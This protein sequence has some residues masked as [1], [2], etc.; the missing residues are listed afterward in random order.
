[1]AGVLAYAA[2]LGAWQNFPVK[3]INLN[4]APTVKFYEG[5]S[6]ASHGLYDVHPV[7]GAV[8]ADGSYVMAGKAIEGESSPASTYKRMFCIKVSSTGTVDWVWGHNPDEKQ[9]AGNAVMQL[10]TVGG[11]HGDIIVVGYQTKDSKFQRSITKLA[12]SNGNH[13]WSATWASTDTSMNGAWEMI[14]MTS[15]GQHVLLAGNSE[16]SDQSEFN[17]KS[18]GTSPGLNAP[19]LVIAV[20]LA[21]PPVHPTSVVS[22]SATEF[23][24]DLSRVIMVS[25]GNVISGT[26]LVQKLPVSKLTASSA[27][28]ASD[29]TWTYTG[30]GYLTSKAARGLSDGSVVA[31][32][33]AA[34]VEK[35]AALVKLSSAGAVTW[36]PTDFA[37]YHG[38]GTDVVV[39]HDQKS[40]VICGQGPGHSSEPAG[41]SYVAGSYFGRLT[42]VSLTGT[43]EWSKSYTSTPYD[44]SAGTYATLIKNECW[45]I[46]PA[47]DGYVVGCGTGI[48]DC[49]YDAGAKKD[50]CDA[51]TPDTRTGAIKRAAS[52]WQ[53]MVF[54]VN[55]AGE[56]QWLRTDQYRNTEDQPNDCAA[57]NQGACKSSA[58]EYPII[59]SD[60]GITS[61]QDEGSGIG[62]LRLNPSHV[63]PPPPPPPPK[64]PPAAAAVASSP[65]PTP[66]PPPP[67]PGAPGAEPIEVITFSLVVAGDL[68]TFDEAAFKINL[69]ASLEGAVTVEDIL[70]ILT[71]ASVNVE[72]KIKAPADPTLKAKTLS[73]LQSVANDPAAASAALGVKVEAIATA[74]VV[75]TVV[76]SE[77]EM[78]KLAAGRSSNIGAIVGGAV[79]GT[80]GVLLLIAFLWFF[81]KRGGAARVVDVAPSRSAQ[82]RKT[83]L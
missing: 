29:V 54:R 36:G 81:K 59:T 71:A 38:E 6:V 12:L 10:P 31:L 22:L 55:L 32:L 52:I 24:P 27:P 35:Q 79:G 57:N 70:L 16:G 76:M 46:Q 51:G 1:M 68:D 43:R 20:L 78:D 13:L 15:D 18:Y 34:D 4:L 49:N 25:A 56:L 37:T 39:S 42:K 40:F 9:D 33:F 2:I 19:I 67:S 5:P 11:T 45:G 65:S 69:A 41:T 60:G 62:I 23:L 17:F 26:A 47:A 77:D 63:S 30:T 3:S 82:P 8:L 28:A 74:P 44:G 7:H 48:E 73:S 21:H 83:E 14:S 58:S 66:T 72:A 53:S 64:S 50:T 80:I 61:I 75:A